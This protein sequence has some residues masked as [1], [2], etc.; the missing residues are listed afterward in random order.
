MDNDKKEEMDK[1]A[2]EKGIGQKPA[3]NPDPRANENIKNTPGNVTD[4]DNASQ[5]TGSEIT[6]GGAG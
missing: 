6:D 3:E 5:K 2:K 4:E 1:I